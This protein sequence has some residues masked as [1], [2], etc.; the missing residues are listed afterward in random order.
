MEKT[1]YIN[2]HHNDTVA[3]ALQPLSAGSV[4]EAVTLT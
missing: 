1:Q 3:V 4:Y 2:I